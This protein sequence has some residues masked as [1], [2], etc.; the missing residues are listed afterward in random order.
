FLQFGLG[1]NSCLLISTKT[2]RI[3]TKT[4]VGTF[5]E[6]GVVDNFKKR[7]ASFI[8]DSPCSSSPCQNGGTSLPNYKYNSFDCLT[9]QG[10][11]V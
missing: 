5:S 6:A 3:T 2:A 4:W 1:A 7:R 8:P 9:E 10:F 11:I